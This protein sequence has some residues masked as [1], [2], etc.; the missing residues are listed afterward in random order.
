MNSRISVVGLRHHDWKDRMDQVCL[1]GKGQMVTMSIEAHNPAEPNAVRTYI[2]RS[3]LGYVGS[4][5]REQVCRT[6]HSSGRS[7]LIGRVSTVDD[8]NKVVWVEADLTEVAP[9]EQPAMESRHRWHYHGPV[10]PM[11]SDAQF[12]HMQADTL[13]MLMQSGCEWNQDMD[14]ALET[15]TEECWRDISAEGEERLSQLY[16]LSAAYQHPP[17]GAD[18]QRRLMGALTKLGSGHTRYKLVNTL[19]H[20]VHQDSTLNFLLNHKYELEHE[21]SALPPNVLCSFLQDPLMFMGKTRYERWCRHDLRGLY[22]QIVV[23]LVLM[24]RHTDSSFSLCETPNGPRLVWGG[25]QPCTDSHAMVTDALNQLSEHY[26]TAAQLRLLSQQKESK[27]L[28]LRETAP[29]AVSEEKNTEKLSNKCRVLFERSRRDDD[30]VLSCE[31]S[32][33]RE[34][35]RSAQ[36]G[37]PFKDGVSDDSTQ[38][39]RSSK[40][41]PPV[42][43]FTCP[44]QESAAEALL[45]PWLSAYYRP[46]LQQIEVGGRNVPA[47]IGLAALYFVLI[48]RR[49]VSEK[50]NVSAFYKYLK[51]VL[52][53]QPC[54]RQRLSDAFSDVIN[55]GVESLRQ[56][57]EAQVQSRYD[58]Y[59]DPAHK[60]TWRGIKPTEFTALWDGLYE[61]VEQS[62]VG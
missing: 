49:L 60:N 7:V 61:A 40:G 25:S 43:L 38:K 29:Q 24:E 21:V 51:E 54:S 46:H 4:A 18:I 8:K 62:L 27:E 23:C 56:L 47:P 22:T 48:D 13:L 52:H 2:G 15:V 33:T 39:I 17:Q 26:Y 12:F 16:A 20:M 35:Y 32:L 57:T 14:E 34:D 30:E 58:K 53:D 3:V 45:R 55:S 9:Q 41:R 10:L 42:F 11:G 36:D 59:Y 19:L 37:H 1:I 6:I 50:S 31:S 28:S 5:Y 44:E